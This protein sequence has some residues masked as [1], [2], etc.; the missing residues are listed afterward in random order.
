MDIDLQQSL[1]SRAKQAD[2]TKFWAVFQLGIMFLV[3]VNRESLDFLVFGL[4]ISHMVVVTYFLWLAEWHWI[5]GEVFRV[6]CA[7]KMSNKLRLWFRLR[8]TDLT[9]QNN[10]RFLVLNKFFQKR[11]LSFYFY[12]IEE[13]LHS[14]LLVIYFCYVSKSASCT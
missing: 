7:I 8:I 14:Y 2:I 12:R 5:Y 13:N 11:L 6:I 1:M 9:F 4:Q 3:F 10:T